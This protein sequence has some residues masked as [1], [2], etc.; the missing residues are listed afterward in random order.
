MPLELVA[1]LATCSR[2]SGFNL[3]HLRMI[4]SADRAARFARYQVLDPDRLYEPKGY[5][6]LVDEAGLQRELIPP[7]RGFL[8]LDDPAIDPAAG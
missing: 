7:E 3:Y 8:P 2:H 1:Q 5:D 6:H 4:A